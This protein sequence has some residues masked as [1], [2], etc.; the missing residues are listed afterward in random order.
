MDIPIRLSPS[1][2][3]I[4]TLAAGAMLRLAEQTA[5]ALTH[6]GT[7]A[8]SPFGSALQATL[9][10]PKADKKYRIEA[11]CS[12]LHTGA[13][14]QQLITAVLEVSYDAGVSW[15]TAETIG[16]ILNPTTQLHVHPRAILATLPSFPNP[17]P[18][19]VIARMTLKK[20]AVSDPVVVNAFGVE[21][22]TA[23][24]YISISEHVP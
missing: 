3:V 2:P 7:V 6:V 15:V 4:A 5:E 18:A 11:E 20:S 23:T 12:L 16:L 17:A 21:G 22:G 8:E 13:A 14:T 19:S 10:N 1:G 9:A 24:G